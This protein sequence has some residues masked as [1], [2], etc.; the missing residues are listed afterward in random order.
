MRGGMG[1]RQ[2]RSAASPIGAGRRAVTGKVGRSAVRAAVLWA[3]A[4]FVLGATF[5]VGLGVMSLT[6]GP[7][8]L[9]PLLEEQRGTQG[10]GCTSLALDRDNGHTLAEPCR[11]EASLRE[12]QTA[13]LSDL[14]QP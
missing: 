7:W 2:R 13:G 14:L 9:A 5:W 4:G 3:T 10:S 6:G 1:E 12:A 8:P 11:G